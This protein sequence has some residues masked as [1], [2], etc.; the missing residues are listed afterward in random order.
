[1][2]TT[3][4]SGSHKQYVLQSDF[5]SPQRRTWVIYI[6]PDEEIVRYPAV[7]ER[8]IKKKKMDEKNNMKFCF[9]IIRYID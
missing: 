3:Y 9:F 5:V 7:R 6:S 8:R 2:S 1:M 4:E